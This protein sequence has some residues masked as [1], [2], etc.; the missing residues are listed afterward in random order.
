MVVGAGHEGVVAGAAA[1]S[2]TPPPSV[3]HKKKR[4][5]N[6]FSRDQSPT[7][8]TSPSK[9]IISMFI[10]PKPKEK[11]KALLSVKDIS[12]AFAVYPERPELISRSPLIKLEGLLGDEEL[13]QSM[14][15]REGWVLFMPEIEGAT[16]NQAVEMLKWVIG[17]LLPLILFFGGGIYN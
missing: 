9:P 14:K 15:A 10:G 6:L 7:R 4:M 5:S 16:G 8:P 12:Q 17:Q 3:Q 1:T 13:A 11:K 2:G